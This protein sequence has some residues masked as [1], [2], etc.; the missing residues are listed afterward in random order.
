MSSSIH[1]TMF[2]VIQENRV[3]NFQKKAE[4]ISKQDT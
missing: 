3:P 4:Y 1:I 2:R